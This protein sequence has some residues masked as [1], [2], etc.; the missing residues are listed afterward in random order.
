MEHA[1]YASAHQKGTE[2]A[3]E[4]ALMRSTLYNFRR[5]GAAASSLR[6]SGI[7]GGAVS[8][9]RGTPTTRTHLNLCTH[10]RTPS[11]RLE[12]GWYVSALPTK[13]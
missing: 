6:N 2:L 1:C 12:E 10:T 5:A 3:N 8:P 11:C 7:K 13:L 4:H 9:P